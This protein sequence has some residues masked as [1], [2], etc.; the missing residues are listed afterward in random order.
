MTLNFV[1]AVLKI[2]RNDKMSLNTREKKAL[3]DCGALLVQDT[4]NMETPTEPPRKKFKDVLKKKKEDRV[5]VSCSKYVAAVK[6]A[7]KGS[8]AEVER[9]WSHA[10]HVMTKDRSS[11]SPLV[12]EAIMYLK[13]NRRLWN[14]TDVV[15]ANKR[16]K[17][18]S[19]AAKNRNE[20]R[21]KVNKEMGAIGEWEAFHVALDQV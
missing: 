19:T 9:L 4:A 3:K 10:G 1:T 7:V 13:Y 21:A 14:L 15:E 5:E 6:E 20:R 18:Q 17:S 16:R 8:G 12:F 2:Q 11:M